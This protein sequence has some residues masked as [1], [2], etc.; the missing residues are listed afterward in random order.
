[1]QEV[2]EGVTV[3]GHLG[4]SVVLVGA[5]CVSSV[6]INYPLTIRMLAVYAAILQRAARYLVGAKL[7]RVVGINVGSRLLS[8]GRVI[9]PCYHTFLASRAD[10]KGFSIV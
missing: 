10:A 5:V 6:R 7:V 3:P 8:N 4:V 1:M 2:V 9:L